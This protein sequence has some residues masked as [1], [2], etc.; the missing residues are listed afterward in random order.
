M[1]GKLAGTYQYGSGFNTD[2]TPSSA[3]IPAAGGLTRE[4]MLYGYDELGDPTTTRGRTTYVTDTKYSK[5][6][7]PLWQ[8][9][10]S[11]T[12]SKR[13]MRYFYY[14]EGCSA[15]PSTSVLGGP[16]PYWSS[17]TYDATGN[18]TREVRHDAGGDVTRTYSYPGAGQ[19]QPH[20]LRSVTTAGGPD[21]GRTDGYGYDA[22]GDTTGRKGVTGQQTL[23]WDA[24]G[25]LTKVTEAGKT[26]SYLYDAD[27]N[28]LVSR[29][30]TGTTLYLPGQ[31]ARLDTAT[32]ATSCTRTYTHGGAAVAVR[33]KAGLTW[34][35]SDHQGTT[36]ASV[37]DSTQAVALRRQD[38]FGQPR[39]TAPAT[40]P[41]AKGFVGGD[42]DASTGLTHLGAR[43]YDPATGR[44]VSADPLIDVADPQQMNGYA[45]AN[46][47]PA[48]LSDPDGLI[49]EDY[50]NGQHG[51][52]SGW[53]QDV[54]AAKAHRPIK[55]HPSYRPIGHYGAAPAY[56]APKPTCGTWNF[57]CRAR[58]AV[59]AAGQWVA[60]HKAVIVSTV[61]AIG[62]GVACEAV[63]AGAGSIGCAMLA[64]A[65]GHLVA[66]AMQGNIHN[67][68]DALTSAALGAAE[69][70]IGLGIGKAVG[71][72]VEAAAP[73]IRTALGGAGKARPLS[74]AAR[75]CH[76]F[77]PA[78]R[79]LMADGTTKPIGKIE[80][81]DKVTATDPTTGKTTAK[82]VTA[83]HRNT[84][85][86]LTDLTIT[87]SRTG[88]KTTSTPRSTGEHSRARAITRG[89]LALT[90]AT[91]LAGATPPAHAATDGTDTARITLHTTQHHPFWDLDH[92]AWVDAG[93]LTTGHRL[94]TADGTPATVTAVR[95]HTGRK[96]MNDLTVAEVHTYHVLAGTTPILVHNC[97]LG[98]VST[99]Q[100]VANNRAAL[101]I[102]GSDGFSGVYDPA[103]RNFHARLSGGG[104]PLVSQFGGHAQINREVFGGSGSTV[105]F[106]VIKGGDGT[107]QMRWNSRSVNERNFGDRAAP[108]GHRDLIMDALRAATGMEVAG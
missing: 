68:G 7:Q 64:G 70:I 19:P 8:T 102:H 106:A 84:D 18:R 58:A 85:T 63:T 43:D 25:H 71:A 15:T 76:S 9:L 91:G 23:E 62:V 89:A 105:G 5:L 48:T 98:T 94:T 2:G 79:V 11:D 24:E 81:G 44:F 26:T 32:Q 38:P 14:D 46:N 33:T 61:V 104:N 93:D 51:G 3:G 74:S 75:S 60:Q 82:T 67:V 1:E 45:Y 35:A 97:N 69:G 80:V 59:S 50:A 99:G 88:K 53:Q 31:E 65:A 100:S 96:A 39:G 4:V 47:N 52:Y 73:S 29:D 34:L 37:A 20:T 95:N 57:G 6:S 87:V 16:A 72:A 40:W 27:G 86:E 54:A 90:L 12:S 21:D 10:R 66:D 41:D 101:N 55:S 78:T 107:L 22:I 30:P 28:R 49:P 92:K 42:L 108:M 103:G 77:D 36:T 13:V 17:F 83:L 56:H